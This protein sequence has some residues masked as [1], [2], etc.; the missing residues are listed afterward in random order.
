MIKDT[1]FYFILK[2]NKTI[3]IEME[4]LRSHWGRCSKLR[5]AQRFV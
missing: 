1:F 3:L 4:Y 2:Y 5:E